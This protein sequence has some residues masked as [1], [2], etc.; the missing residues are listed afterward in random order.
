MRR[1]TRRATVSGRAGSNLMGMHRC[2][3][4]AREGQVTAASSATGG[5]VQPAE[6]AMRA[7]F[8]KME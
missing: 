4:R 2:V 8:R 6:Q 3:E 7:V 5:K 1:E